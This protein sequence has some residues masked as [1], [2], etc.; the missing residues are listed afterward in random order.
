MYT[1]LN[2]STGFPNV[3]KNT[4]QFLTN[5]A[6]AIW[7]GLQAIIPEMKF[8]C[9]GIITGWTGWFAF[10]QNFKVTQSIRLQVWRPSCTE[11]QELELVGTNLVL[12]L[13]EENKMFYEVNQDILE[14]RRIA[15]HPGDVIGFQVLNPTGTAQPATPLIS[16]SSDMTMYHTSFTIQQPTKLSLCDSEVSTLKRIQPQVSAIVGKHL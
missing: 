14:A 10:N 8:T 11:D 6:G 12:V 2:C 7:T 4:T 3:P 13:Y 1:A 16:N 15:F 5:E 9:S